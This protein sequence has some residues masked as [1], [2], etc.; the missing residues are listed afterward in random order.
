MLC[1]DVFSVFSVLIRCERDYVLPFIHSLMPVSSI[2]F[3]GD[4]I[5]ICA[6]RY[7]QL[8][9]KCDSA[10]TRLCRLTVTRNKC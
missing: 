9:L 4:I 7:C 6:S 5:C 2:F 3:S 10:A 1:I 8:K